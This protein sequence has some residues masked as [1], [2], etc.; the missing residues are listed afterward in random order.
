MVEKSRGLEGYSLST[1]KNSFE[2][3]RAYDES[4]NWDAVEEPDP[5]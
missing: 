2:M 3:G 1:A 4:W 5:L